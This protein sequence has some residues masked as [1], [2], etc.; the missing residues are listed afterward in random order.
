MQDHV[1]REPSMEN[2]PGDDQD[3]GGMGTMSPVGES[4]RRATRDL[5]QSPGGRTF[6]SLWTG[7]P[8]SLLGTSIT[9]FALAVYIFERTG[10]ATPVALTMLAAFLPQILLGP[11]A[12]SL[13]NRPHRRWALHLADLGQ[14]A[15]VLAIA[16]LLGAGRPEVWMV[17]VLVAVGSA[18]ACMQW[19]AWSA[20]VTLLVPGEHLGRADGLME[21]GEG[22][23]ILVGPAA[24]GVL[25]LTLGISRVLWLDVAS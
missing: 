8:L 22:P 19:A 2:G 20:T 24:A 16:L 25:V 14:G 18:A 13:V 15:S 9:D 23:G 17:Y 11:L 4:A 10:R 5:L 3:V 21:F 6:L 7:Q 12:G 1:R